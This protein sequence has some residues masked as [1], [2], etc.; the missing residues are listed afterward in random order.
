MFAGDVHSDDRLVEFG[1]RRLDQLEV[2]VLLDGKNRYEQKGRY[3]KGFSSTS[4]KQSIS[5]C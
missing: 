5:I 4:Q 1:I 2:D 3:W